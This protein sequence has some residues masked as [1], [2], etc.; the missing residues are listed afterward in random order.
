[1]RRLTAWSCCFAVILYARA[2]CA[3]A[4]AAPAANDWPQF[5]GPGGQGVSQATHVPVRWGA[6]QN[7]AWKVPIPGR[8]WSSPVLSAGRLYLTIAVEDAAGAATAAS[9]A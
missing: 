3:A 6:T 2:A 7:V 9:G 4:L 5:R 8:G 1:M